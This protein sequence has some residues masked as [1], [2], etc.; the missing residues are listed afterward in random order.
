MLTSLRRESYDCV[1][2]EWLGSVISL[3]R[4][5]SFRPLYTC[6]VRQMRCQ[7]GRRDTEDLTRN[8]HMACKWFGL[9]FEV[10]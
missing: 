5:M 10:P 2:I 1:R 6:E 9:W 7:K 3:L 4:R 8:R